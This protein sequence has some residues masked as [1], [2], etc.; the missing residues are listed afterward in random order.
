[1]ILLK[2][3]SEIQGLGLNQGFFEMEGPA[4]PMAKVVVEVALCWFRISIIEDLLTAAYPHKG[5]KSIPGF[6]NN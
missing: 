5:V 3:E 1:M 2:P 6:G 4:L